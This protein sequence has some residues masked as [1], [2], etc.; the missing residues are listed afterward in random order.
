MGKSWNNSIVCVATVLALV[1]SPLRA[2]ASECSASASAATYRASE[3]A[4]ALG[5]FGYR[6]SQSVSCNQG[7]TTENTVEFL[8]PNGGVLGEVSTTS[9]PS[10]EGIRHMDFQGEVLADYAI[11][12]ACAD[13]SCS[14]GEITGSLFGV[15]MELS[16]ASLDDP[17]SA[18]IATDTESPDATI[19]QR[20]ELAYALLTLAVE[21]TSAP[22]LDDLFLVLEP[23]ILAGGWKN[24]GC[25][26]LCMAGCVF[27]HVPVT[28]CWT[29]CKSICE[30]LAPPAL[31]PAPEG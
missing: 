10:G 17:D 2:T 11:F 13:G 23:S 3:D 16:Y 27:A 26:M 8:G 29:G 22:G 19:D 4:N 31:P 1:G 5:I 30:R 28:L 7:T 21:D 14:G 6:V 15:D 18:A 24:F 20:A 12:P 25:M 9:L